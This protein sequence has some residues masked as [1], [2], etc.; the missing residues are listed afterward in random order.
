[1][2]ARDLQFS[3]WWL[4][5]VQLEGSFFVSFLPGGLS[6]DIYRTYAIAR[7]TERALD[8]VSSVLLEKV[9]GLAA[10]MFISVVSLLVGR[11]WLETTT[12]AALSPPV[13]AVA[14]VFFTILLLVAFVIR[15]DLLR[16]WHLPIPFWDR[17]QQV[18]S[19]LSA[20]V[21]D[22]RVL[23]TLALLSLFLQLSIVLWYFT[24]ATALG[25]GLSL[26]ALLIVVPLV[27]LFLVIPVSVGG[28]GL[29]DGA[30]IILLLPFGLSRE[31]AVAFSLLMAATATALR[32]LSGIAFLFQSRRP[33]L[34][35]T[36]AEQV[37]G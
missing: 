15:N 30:L 1:L 18:T 23:T 35:H 2:G 17:L 10:M 13:F 29:R 37:D 20:R 22:R 27:E 36:H 6:G 11:N 3:F 7:K 4:W 33:S 5:L 9:I 25:L 19:Q 31:D 16:R 14:G 12:F 24:V 34:L 21:Y 26:L 32:A 8:S 28:I